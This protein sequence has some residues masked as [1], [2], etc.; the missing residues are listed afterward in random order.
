MSLVLGYITV[1]LYI[2]GLL[3]SPLKGKKI[4]GKRY[5]FKAHIFTGIAMTIVCLVHILLSDVKFQ[6]SAGIVSIFFVFLSILS[7]IIAF[8]IAHNYLFYK[9]T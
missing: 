5:A 7:G 1:F 2:A 9:L 3:Y 8:K 6:F 4:F